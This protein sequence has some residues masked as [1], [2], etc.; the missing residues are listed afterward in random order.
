MRARREVADV[1]VREDAKTNRDRRDDGRQN[2][3]TDVGPAEAGPHRVTAGCS[4]SQRSS[5]I[6]NSAS[7]IENPIA[8]W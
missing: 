4:R 3:S 6:T 7:S 2:R 1:G 5:C 8:G